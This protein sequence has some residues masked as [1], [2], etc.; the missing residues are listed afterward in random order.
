MLEILRYFAD[1]LPRAVETVGASLPEDF[2]PTVYQTI[3]SHTLRNHARLQSG[4][5]G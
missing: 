4:L 3:I 5:A 1:N 2:S